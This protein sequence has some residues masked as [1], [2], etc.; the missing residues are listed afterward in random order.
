MYIYVARGTYIG[1]GRYRMHAC[2][3]KCCDF[4]QKYPFMTGY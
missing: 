4:V 1:V 3:I 2:G